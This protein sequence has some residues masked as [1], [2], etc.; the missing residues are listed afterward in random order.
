[1]EDEASTTPSLITSPAS[2]AAAHGPGITVTHGH[3]AYSFLADGALFTKYHQQPTFLNSSGK[4]L[5]FYQHNHLF[6]LKA[7]VG[8]PRPGE[9]ESVGVQYQSPL[10]SI[11]QVVSGKTESTFRSKQ[12]AAVP[13]EKAWSLIVRRKDGKEEHVD[14]E[15]AS[16]EQRDN[17]VKALQVLVSKAKE[18]EMEREAK[19]KV[20]ELH[21]TVDNNG[22]VL[23]TI[24]PATP[25]TP[26]VRQEPSLIHIART[27]P[28]A[29]HAAG[30]HISP[31]AAADAA[32][33]SSAA[34]ASVRTAATSTTSLPS[35][36]NGA[37]TDARVVALSRENEQLKST[38]AELEERMKTT[39]VDSVP[40]S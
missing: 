27:T 21:Y 26:P 4:R 30:V 39:Q 31:P 33:S 20:V 9:E 17:W 29:A 24:A 13:E 28:G 34:A 14:L 36:S 40:A 38:I 11:V 8:R 12:A 3:G 10:T 35:S 6:W 1:M 16:T 32:S 25:R 15:A 5:V 23:I 19:L 2:L 37:D 22:S 18:T 7:G